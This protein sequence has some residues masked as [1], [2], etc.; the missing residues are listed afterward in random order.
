MAFRQRDAI[1]PHLAELALPILCANG[2]HD[3]MIHAYNSYAATQRASD[4]QAIIYPGSAHGF[5]F[6][7]HAWFACDVHQFLAG[8]TKGSL[9]RNE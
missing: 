4:A 1:Y 2:A 9:K 3:V 8:A 6:E 7:H 5:F